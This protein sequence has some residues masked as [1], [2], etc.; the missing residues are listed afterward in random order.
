MFL[1]R[2]VYVKVERKYAERVKRLLSEYG[3]LRHDVPVCRENDHVLF[4]VCER[5]EEIAKYVPVEFVERDVAGRRGYR[6][7]RDRLRGVVPEELFQ[8][9]PRSFEILGEI[10]I[11][12][13]PED[14]QQYEKQVG[15]ALLKH[16]SKLRAVYAKEGPVSGKHRTPVLK[17]IA[18]EPVYETCYRESGAVFY[19]APGRV[20]ASI[21][22][23]GE[24]LRVAQ[25]VQPGEV[26]L[27]MFSGIGGFAVL[28][29]RYV[30]RVLV[31]AV[32]INPVAV[33]YLAKNVAVN[34]L[35]GKVIPIEGDARRVAYALRNKF[36][37]VI[38]DLPYESVS[39]LDAAL[40]AVREKGM[41]HVY[42]VERERVVLEQLYQ[43][44][45]E[46]EIIYRREI[47]EIAPYRPKFVY[48]ILV[49]ERRCSNQ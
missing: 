26:V 35:W 46:V 36:S 5:C 37:R 48:D 11:I 27:D 29:A 10:A 14:L 8:R 49:H 15:E 13:I 33:R 12:E 7:Y 34:K 41:I 17:L 23:S 43:L 38:M 22:L 4:P 42:T 3:V 25:Q 32:D 28:I 19:F 40:A 9:L 39:F 18:G 20:Y 24:R 31:Y 21:K 45:A 30:Q 44:G 6:T 2:I 47:K 16:H 1:G